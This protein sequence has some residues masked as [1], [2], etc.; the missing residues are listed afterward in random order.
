MCG[1]KERYRLPVV[2]LPLQQQIFVCSKQ[3][4]ELMRYV[5]LERSVLGGGGGGES[6]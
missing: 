2:R 6:A 4:S 1:C 5:K 3:V